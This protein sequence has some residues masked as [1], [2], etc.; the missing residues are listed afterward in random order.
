V[1]YCEGS[2][3]ICGLEHFE[4]VNMADRL[5]QLQDAVNQQAAYFCNSIG[6]LQQFAQPSSFPTFGNKTPQQ[7]PPSQEDH[8]QL[9]AQLIARTAKDIEVLIDSLPSEESTAELQ[10]AGLQQ[11]EQEGELA[12]EQMAQVVRTGEQLLGGIQFA[13]HD[14]ATK[15]LEMERLAAEA[16]IQ[17]TSGNTL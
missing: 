8:T 9:F 14:I 4:S 3:S 7:Q 1:D 15:Q 10:A 2:A 6:L 13:L 16:Q 5:T 11:L 12:G 17:V